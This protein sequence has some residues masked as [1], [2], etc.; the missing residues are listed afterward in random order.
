MTT[1]I[2]VLPESTRLLA[3]AIL[4]A[5]RACRRAS[6]R[7]DVAVAIAPYWTTADEML[8]YLEVAGIPVAGVD[9]RDVPEYA[10]DLQTCATCSQHIVPS[11]PHPCSGGAA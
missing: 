1:E 9:I 8:V 11:I 2:D 3:L 6:G 7:L 4:R 5:A 10:A